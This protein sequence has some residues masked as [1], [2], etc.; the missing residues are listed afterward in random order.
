[1]PANVMALVTGAAGVC[2]IVAER[3]WPGPRRNRVWE[4]EAGTAGY[5]VRLI[6]KQHATT[7]AFQR[8][9]AAYQSITPALGNDRTADLVAVDETARALVLTRIPGTP[10][11]CLRL[12]ADAMTEVY[13][14]AGTLLAALHAHPAPAPAA[15]RVTWQD[16]LAQVTEELTAL[17]DETATM[18]KDLLHSG[19]PPRL[20]LITAHGDWMP[21]NW[22]WDDHRLRIIDFEDTGSSPAD[23]TDL[24]RLGYRVLRGHP[25]LDAAFRQGFGRAF[26][27]AE[28]KAMRLSA[29]LDALRALRWGRIHGDESTL[30]EAHTMLDHLHADQYQPWNTATR[31][32][33]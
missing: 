32:A 20:S 11:S 29:A 7:G 10:V 1:M 23:R 31:S 16:E 5:G 6:V 21:R 18:L 4:V 19:P 2:R 24:A 8:E 15:G 14:Q 28:H 25:D 30:T 3:S 33:A 13:R 17:P 26:T 9:A 27:P 22:L 12:D